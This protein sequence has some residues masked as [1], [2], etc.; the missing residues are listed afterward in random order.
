MVHLVL[1]LKL[2][3]TLLSTSENTSDLINSTENTW[4]IPDKYYKYTVNQVKT[5]ENKYLW[6]YCYSDTAHTTENTVYLVNTTRNYSSES[7]CSWKYCYS[8]KHCYTWQIL[9]KILSTWYALQENTVLQGEYY[10]KYC[11]PGEYY[12]IL[13]LMG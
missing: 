5:T 12:K 13:L 11:W 6:K 8:G 2:L 4:Q 3:R 7:K 9:M 1:L 10:L